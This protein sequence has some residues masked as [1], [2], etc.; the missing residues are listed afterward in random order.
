MDVDDDTSD[1]ED[2]LE[3]FGRD[4][5]SAFV[6]L[7]VQRTVRRRFTGRVRSA[8]IDGVVVS[9]VTASPHRVIRTAE[10]IAV[11]GGHW[12][13]TSLQQSGTAVLQQDGR[14]VLLQP[15]DIAVYDTVRPY[16]LTFPDDY[17]TLVMM[18]PAE[19]LGV[20]AGALATLTARR[21]GSDDGLGAIVVPMLS[22]LV[23]S[24]SGSADALG[25][26]IVS[27]ALDLLSTMLDD[28]L[29]AFGRRDD[30]KDRVWKQVA[31]YIEAHLGAP[32]L[33][34]ESIAAAHYMSTRSLH[35]LFRAHGVSV[36]RWVKASR[37]ERCRRELVDPLMRSESVAA[38]ARR[39]GF[40]DAAAFSRS[41]RATYGYPPSAVRPGP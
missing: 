5:S 10:S 38:I 25:P 16:S 1:E 20:P 23:E 24:V 6:T 13:K 39:W 3:R 12:I 2:D 32:G 29:D 19:R 11:D 15:G 21:F 14:S 8:M 41:F 31:W 36:A 9:Q 17:R 22:S 40:A 28:G 37:L 33:T 27:S 35:S 34:P 30:G 4:V 18:C 7:E 26:R